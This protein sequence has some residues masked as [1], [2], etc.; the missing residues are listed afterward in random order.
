MANNKDKDK[1]RL[2]ALVFVS[3]GLLAGAGVSTAVG[4]IG[5]AV[6]EIAVGIGLIPIAAAGAVVGLAAY[7]LKKII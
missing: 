2:E 7:G 5:L 4:G 1:D 3:S 6:A